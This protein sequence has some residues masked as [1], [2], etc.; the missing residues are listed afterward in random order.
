MPTYMILG[1]CGFIGRAVVEYIQKEELAQKVRVV[2]K[3]SAEMANMIDTQEEMFNDENFVEFIQADLSRDAMVA[4]AFQ[5]QKFD[6]IINCAGDNELGLD[7]TIYNE[8][9]VSLTE[10]CAKAAA[11]AGSKFI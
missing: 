7:E 10:K 4:K 11:A 2:D 8:R 1:G 3:R 6:Y 5:G 9:V